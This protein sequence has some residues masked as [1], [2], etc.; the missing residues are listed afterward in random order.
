MTTTGQTITTPTGHTAHVAI[1]KSH[2]WRYEGQCRRYRFYTTRR[3]VW[4][5]VHI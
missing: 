3:G 2:S 5:A 4:M 1:Q